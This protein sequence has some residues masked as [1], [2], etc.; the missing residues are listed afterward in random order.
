MLPVPITTRARDEDDGSVPASARETAERD[1][2]DEGDD[3]PEPEAPG[4]RDHDSNDHEDPAQADT[5]NPPLRRST[6]I[7]FLLSHGALRAL[8]RAPPT[9]RHGPRFSRQQ[10]FRLVPGQIHLPG[11]AARIVERH[12]QRGTLA[13]LDFRPR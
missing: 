2:A 10:P 5:A 7:H 9:P 1:Q 8:L 6:A 4:D 12:A 3:D 13:V 11:A